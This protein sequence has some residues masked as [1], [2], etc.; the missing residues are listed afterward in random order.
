M[1][2][3]S[4]GRCRARAF[5]VAWAAA[6]LTGLFAG[7]SCQAQPGPEGLQNFGQVTGT[8]FRGAQPSLE[9][10]RSLQRMGVTIV[11]NFRNDD[12]SA[13][14]KHEVEALGMKYVSI[15][16]SGRQNPSSQQIVQFLDLVRAN[17]QAKI[18]V[19]CQRG[20]D[21][22]GTMVAA[23]RIAVEHDSTNSA[24]AEMRQY[25]YAHF[26]LPQLQR[27]VVSLPQLIQSD[28]VF[29]AYAA[30][31]PAAPVGPAKSAIATLVP[32]AP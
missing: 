20:A 28:T 3:A 21:R 29:N 23:Y 6:L 4:S 18:F 10:F 11:V 32:V 22:T 13:R 16:W 26:F 14:E 5:S 19:H 25:H 30:P 31:V 27:Y 2:L 17:P 12:E 8:L 24:V 7:A 15:P 1:N 9:G